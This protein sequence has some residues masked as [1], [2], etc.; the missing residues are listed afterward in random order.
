MGKKRS[1]EQDGLSGG[2]ADKSVDKM[3]EGSSDEEVSRHHLTVF[4]SM[5]FQE[6]K[7]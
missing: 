1:R 6:Q 5:K 3:D 4:H 7:N 2:A